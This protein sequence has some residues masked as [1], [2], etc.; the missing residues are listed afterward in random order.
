M[1]LSKLTYFTG[2]FLEAKSDLIKEASVE[3]A[4]KCFKEELNVAITGG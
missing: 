2:V 4:G 1:F 3:E